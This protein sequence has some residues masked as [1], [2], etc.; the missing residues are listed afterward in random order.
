MT[1]E[2]KVSSKGQIVIPKYLRDS[3]GLKEGDVVM[4]AKHE[5]R[6]II[7]KKPGDPLA[8]LSE[9]GSKVAIKNIRRHIK[10]E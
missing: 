10:E 9:T 6:L 2:I 4:I 5:N 3:L 7:M 8:A 1:E